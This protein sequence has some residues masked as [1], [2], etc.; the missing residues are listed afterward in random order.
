MDLEGMQMTAGADGCW[1]AAARLKVDGNMLLRLSRFLIEHSPSECHAD[2]GITNGPLMPKR[3]FLRPRTVPKH[4]T[5]ELM[6]SSYFS[7]RDTCMLYRFLSDGG[8]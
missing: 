8:E 7:T 4:G 5:G 6:S 2:A 3:T 1:Q